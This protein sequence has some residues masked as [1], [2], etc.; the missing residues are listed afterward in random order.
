MTSIAAAQDFKIAAALE[1]SRMMETSIFAAADPAVVKQYIPNGAPASMSSFVLVAGDDTILFD[2]G[3]G[4]KSWIDSITQL[5]VKAENIKLILLTHLHPDHIGGLLDGETRR[6]PNAKVRCSIPEY[7]YWLPKGQKPRTKQLALIQSVY[8]SD[9]VGD[10]A[11]DATVFSNAVVKVKALDAVGHTPG[12]TAFLIESPKQRFLIVG[13]L[14]HAAALQFPRPEICS[15]Y[16]NAP[17]QTVVSRK[18]ILDLAVQE[19][20]PIGGMHLPAPS[21]GT[22]KKDDKEGYIF[23]LEG[24]K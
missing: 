4:S 9:F 20:L 1:V 12:H 2:A 3:L 11:F 19:K 21:I 23:T 6:F 18:R 24:G 17:T 10:C 16:D 13:D 5:G 22:V 15:S 8:G 7:E 14:L